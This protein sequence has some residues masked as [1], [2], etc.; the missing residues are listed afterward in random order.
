M[1]ATKILALCA[2]LAAPALA[3]AA[4]QSGN[5]LYALMTGSNSQNLIA[6]GY[7]Q[8][9]SDTG[10]GLLFCIPPRVTTQQVN[11]LVLQDLRAHPAERH[12]EADTFVIRALRETWPC[13][14]K[15]PTSYGRPL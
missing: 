9:V 11:D 3:Q 5:E 4:F 15:S 1:K 12:L 6:Y 10:G 13:P 8:G 7:V 2:A 14:A